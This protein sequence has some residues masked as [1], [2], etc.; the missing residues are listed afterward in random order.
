M[1]LEFTLPGFRYALG[2]SKV[3][4]RA[5]AEQG[6]LF[7][8]AF[9]D[10]PYELGLDIVG[11]RPG[12]TAHW[13]VPATLPLLRP[14]APVVYWN[15]EST[16]P[17]WVGHLRAH[18]ATVHDP[19][20]WDKASRYFDHRAKELLLVATVGPTL[21]V[22]NDDDAS[23]WVHRTVR[24]EGRRESYK[25]PK[26]LALEKRA[27]LRFAPPG[28]RVLDATAGGG[29]IA[30]AC[31]ALGLEYVGFEIEPQH[32]AAGVERLKLLHRAQQA[33]ARLGAAIQR[34]G[35]TVATPC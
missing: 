5:L 28:A 10:V 12:E 26:P 15:A 20:R 24:D 1:A 30:L 21:T 23:T 32:A 27:L 18:G 34:G 4:L 7:D 19:I 31:L 33:N 25:T 17:T 3:E 6:E 35:A 16:A 11:D 2:D 14:G 22:Y 9:S 29:D 13:I 8:I